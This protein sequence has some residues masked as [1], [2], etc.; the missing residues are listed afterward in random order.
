M[1]INSQNNGCNYLG[2]WVDKRTEIGSGIG[3]RKCLKVG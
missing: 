2:E 1:Y 3:S